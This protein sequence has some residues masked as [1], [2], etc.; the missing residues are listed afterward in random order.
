MNAFYKIVTALAITLLATSASARNDIANYSIA[1]ALA[2]EEAK[3]ILGNDIKFYFGTQ[4]HGD[5][6][7]E[8]TVSS[9]NRKTNGTNKTDK[10]AC[11]WVFLSSLK[12]LR[13]RAREVGGNAVVNIRSNYQHNT[14]TSNETFQCGSGTFTSGVALIG[15]VVTIKE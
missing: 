11:N 9:V 15:D 2:D 5:V 12:A 8:H 7:T 13:D 3:A 6:I 10:V 4:A 14:T 1:D